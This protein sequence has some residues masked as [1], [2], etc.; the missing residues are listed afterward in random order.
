MDN[1][2]TRF[3]RIG[4]TL[5]VWKPDVW[6]AYK[7]GEPCGEIIVRTGYQRILNK[8]YNSPFNWFIVPEEY[9][10]TKINP[11]A[12]HQITEED[13]LMFING[14]TVPEPV[15]EVCG[16]DDYYE[17]EDS[18]EDEES[19]DSE[20][21]VI[22][23]TVYEEPQVN[24]FGQPMPTAE[25]TRLRNLQRERNRPHKGYDLLPNDPTERKRE[26]ARRTEYLHNEVNRHHRKP[27]WH[28][29]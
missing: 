7:E 19:E 23:I 6:I 28:S 5:C 14:I 16:E 13:Y 17:D 29:S 3:T 12:N 9:Y 15:Q 21:E 27:Y 20:E 22:E 24:I 1:S 18:E 11:K 25:E 8:L 10:C 2:T 4:R 26:M